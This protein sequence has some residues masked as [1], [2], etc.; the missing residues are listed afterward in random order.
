MADVLK[1][2][3]EMRIRWIDLEFVDVVGGAHHITVASHELDF[4]AFKSGVG[5]INGTNI[6]GFKEVDMVLLPDPYTFT[7]IPWE[8]DTGRMLCDV[9]EG[10]ESGECSYNSR[11]VARKAEDAVKNAGYSIANFSAEIEFFVFD[12]ATFDVHTPFRSQG[13]LVESREAAWNAFG[14]NFPIDFKT[15]HYA[16]PPQDTMQIYRALVSN[17]L[18]D[19]YGIP[20]EAHHHGSANPGQCEINI[21]YSSILK[22]G[23]SVITYKYVAKNIASQSGLIATFMPKPLFGDK[24]SSMHT[25]QSLWIEEKNV[26]YDPNEAYAEISQT[27]RYY[28]G[29]LMEHAK[30]LSLLSLASTNSY[31]RL[32]SYDVSPYIAWSRQNNSAAIRI[33]VYYKGNERTK[34]IE[35]KPPDPSSNSY[36]V[37][38]GLLLAG[39]DGIKKKTECGDPID[40]NIYLMDEKKRKELGI[41]KLPNSLE[42]ALD[43]FAS[44]NNFLKPVF[45]DE[46][47]E[48][49]M[50]LKR[51]EYEENASRP[52]PY[53]FKL[54]LNV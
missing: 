4:D 47:I 2:I 8:K 45:S 3:E 7:L 10:G 20:V 15:G 12:S 13:Y 36:L 33:P 40:E 6:K 31:K 9:R 1:Q 19:I 16:I 18:E 53:E 42:E 21:G 34:R 23:D 25:H 46:L 52:T 50:E 22:A 48:T 54:Y 17:T 39:L 35:Y 14:Q 11:G 26:F 28:I 49:Y 27:C 51:K 38:A 37:F 41:R 43:E 24:G 30:A 29:G 44:D 5:K 32:A